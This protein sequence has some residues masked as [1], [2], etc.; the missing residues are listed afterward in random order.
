MVSISL[1]N[2]VFHCPSLLSIGDIYD[3]K[4]LRM[5]GLSNRRENPFSESPR[6]FR[7]PF[8]DMITMFYM[9]QLNAVLT[10]RKKDAFREGSST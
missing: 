9:P 1:T 2:T 8:I 6:R 7:Y 4:T 5:I 10:V 3:P